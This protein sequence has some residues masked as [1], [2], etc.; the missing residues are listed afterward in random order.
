MFVEGLDYQSGQ[1]IR[2]EFRNGKINSVDRLEDSERPLPLIAPGLVDLQVNG[3]G[4]IDFNK[5]PFQVNDVFHVVQ[6]LATQGVI[7]FFPTLI[8]NKNSSIREALQTIVSACKI[9]Q[10]IETVIGGIH[11]EGPFLSKENGARGAHSLEFIQEPNWELFQEW[12]EIAE[13]KIRIITLSPEWEGA[14]QI[15]KKMY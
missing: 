11:L 7:S 10:L 9:D 3:Y 8:T 13:G 1:A 2:M 5:I 14:A 15:H 12:Q 4:G 6:K